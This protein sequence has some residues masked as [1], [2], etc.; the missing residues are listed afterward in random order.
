MSWVF[1]AT[2]GSPAL[3]TSERALLVAAIAAAGALTAAVIGGLATYFSS[4]RQR[5]LEIYGEAVKA[6]LSWK[7]LLYRVRRRARGDAAARSIIERF[8]D[9]QDTLTY[10]DGWIAADSKFMARSYRHLVLQTKRQL[11]G[12]IQDAWAARIRPVP[13]SA[14]AG[15]V[16][17]DLQPFLDDFMADVRSHLSWQPWRRVAVVC[18]NTKAKRADVVREA[19]GSTK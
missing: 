10:Y 13:G 11:E 7:E 14:V 5:R 1:A 3:T 17:P 4:K 2:K 19:K 6:A 16:H 8:H 18:R 12:P 9:A 15:D